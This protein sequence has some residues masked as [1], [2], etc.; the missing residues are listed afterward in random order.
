MREHYT[1]SD[2]FSFLFFFLPPHKTCLETVKLVMHGNMSR[3]C[4]IHIYISMHVF[5]IIA[6]D[7]RIY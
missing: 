3:L 6:C 7:N 2:Y 1:S 5:F 4:N